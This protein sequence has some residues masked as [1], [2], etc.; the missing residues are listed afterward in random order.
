MGLFTDLFGSTPQPTNKIIHID[1][2]L[3]NVAIV[4]NSTPAKET[5]FANYGIDAYNKEAA[6]F[7]FRDAKIGMATY[8]QMSPSANCICEVDNSDNATTE[9]FDALAH[10]RTESDKNEAII[11]LFDTFSPIEPSKKM[12]YS[13]YI[14]IMRKLLKLSGKNVRINELYNY[15]IEDIDNLNRRSALP[16]IDKDR[17]ER[18]LNSFRS[19]AIGIESYFRVFAENTIGYIMSGT[20][21]LDKFFQTKDFMEVTFDFSSKQ[22][23]SEILLSA[24]IDNILKYNFSASRKNKIFVIADEIPNDALVNTGFIR[25]LKMTNCHVIFSISNIAGLVKISND[26]VDKVNCF[27]FLCQNSNENTEYCAKMFGEHEVRKPIE[28]DGRTTEAPSLRNL[29]GLLQ[30]T[31]PTVNKQTTWQIVKE[32]VYPPEVF[33]QLGDYETIYYNIKDKEQCRLT[34]K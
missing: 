11:K 6:I 22:K 4:G 19:D 15:S 34:L 28:S 9:Q 25:L 30:T 16:Q 3:G 21:T 32:Y 12:T 26:W 31:K 14:D 5:L 33:A 23:D 17:N 18:S 7:V 29:G 2:N 10:C 1:T 20:K 27:F 8:P 24:F 13:T